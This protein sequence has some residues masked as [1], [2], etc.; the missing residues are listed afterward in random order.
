VLDI[1]I[2]YFGKIY[3]VMLI[4]IIMEKILYYKDKI[5]DSLNYIRETSTTQIV[6]LALP[7]IDCSRNIKDVSA[8]LLYFCSDNLNPFS[9]VV[10]QS[11]AVVALYGTYSLT[12]GSIAVFIINDFFD[13]FIAIH[14]ITSLQYSIIISLLSVL[15]YK[16]TKLSL[17]GELYKSYGSLLKWNDGK[18][19]VSKHN[20]FAIL[21]FVTFLYPIMLLVLFMKKMTP[22]TCILGMVPFLVISLSAS[23]R[24]TMCCN[25][26]SYFS[27]LDKKISLTESFI[28][29]TVMF[30]IPIFFMWVV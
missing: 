14:I 21:M 15:Y 2:K 7:I 24:D 4:V 26:D 13:K 22:F 17:F 19:G 23:N 3:K 12:H 10:A 6:S 1:S 20:F 11:A 28:C 8:L 18:N 9:L 16:R 5:C 29:N 30:F 25:Y 27:K